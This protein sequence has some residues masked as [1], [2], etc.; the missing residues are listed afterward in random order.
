MCYFSASGAVE[1]HTAREESITNGVQR[2]APG[3]EVSDPH[4]QSTACKSFYTFRAER[5]NVNLNM[6][7]DNC[8]SGRHVK[9][10]ITAAG[11]LPRCYLLDFPWQ[12]RC[13]Q[14]VRIASRHPGRSSG[15]V[16][17]SGG[18]HGSSINKRSDRGSSSLST[19]ANQTAPRVRVQLKPRA[20]ATG[21]RSTKD[22]SPRP[23]QGVG[24][25]GRW[26]AADKNK[27]Q[28]C[29][30]CLTLHD[31][32]KGNKDTAPPFENCTSRNAYQRRLDLRRRRRWTIWSARVDGPGSH[33]LRALSLCGRSLSL[34]RVVDV[35]KVCQ[36]IGF[37]DYRR[38]RS[39]GVVS[40]LV[41]VCDRFQPT[42]QQISDTHQA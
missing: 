38:I 23:L 24:E 20:A 6:F 37:P 21:V 19:R 11:S 3:R 26:S 14:R 12:Y 36:D 4:K 10:V 33:C 41:R 15:M 31:Q 35:G 1:N 34:L 42:L 39:A 22:M 32:K 7:P 17:R 16:D 18:C 13:Q 30:L 2:T 5:G 25:V 27:E 29:R 8:K 40:P 9:R 28:D